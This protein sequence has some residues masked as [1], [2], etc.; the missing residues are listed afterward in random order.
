MEKGG[1]VIQHVVRSR[2]LC[3]DRDTRGECLVLMRDEVQVAQPEAKD[4]KDCQQPPQAG[5]GRRDPHLRVSHL[6]F[7]PLASRTM[8]EYISV[9]LSRLV[10]GVA[11]SPRK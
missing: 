6:E 7:G 8:R 9:V 1:P 3:E 2:W 11:L 4:V 5:R 10:Y